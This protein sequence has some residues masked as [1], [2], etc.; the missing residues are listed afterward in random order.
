[1]AL[2]DMLAALLVKVGLR[3]SEAARCDEAILRHEDRIRDFNG[4]LAD[5]LDEVRRLEARIRALKAEY[6]KAGGAGKALC[7]ARLRSL[8]KDF[9][10]SKELQDLTLR[11]LEREKLLLQNRRLER[12]HLRHPTDVEAVEDAL[13]RKDEL[14]QETQEED[15]TLAE[16]EGRVYRR[17]E[18]AA[19]APDD[20]QAEARRAAQLERDLA[21]VLGDAPAAEAPQPKEKEED[22]AEAA[23]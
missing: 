13:E 18:P 12:E 11:N 16:L 3:K 20:A 10:R 6:D 22:A 7:E 2:N 4:L 1:M 9:A 17:E 8:M 21:A 14:V 5:Q 19:G 15:E 23:S